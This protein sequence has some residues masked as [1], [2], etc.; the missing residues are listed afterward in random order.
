[1]RKCKIREHGLGIWINSKCEAQGDST[2]QQDKMNGLHT[3]LQ[4]ERES[5][6][7]YGKERERKKTVT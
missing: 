7:E 3:N 6:K 4:K 2:V 5:E 1:M